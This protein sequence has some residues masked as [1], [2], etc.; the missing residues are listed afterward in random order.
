M[1]EGVVSGVDWVSCLFSWWRWIGRMGVG[2]GA[3]DTFW[4]AGRDT[5]QCGRD[6]DLSFHYIQTKMGIFALKSNLVQ[7]LEAP[8]VACAASQSNRR[9]IKHI[10]YHHTRFGA[11]IS[12]SHWAN[13]DHV[14]G[15]V[16]WCFLKPWSFMK[17]HRDS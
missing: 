2:E 7:L 14:A 3:Y 5:N 15:S 9:L 17:C 4:G 13:R 10:R 16:P 1:I 11:N 8:S 12:L 6:L